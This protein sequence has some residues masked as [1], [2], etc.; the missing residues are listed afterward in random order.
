MLT[1][2]GRVAAMTQ[3]LDAMLEATKIVRPALENFYG[4]LTDEQKARFNQLTP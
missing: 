1:P 3:R 2:P 4:L